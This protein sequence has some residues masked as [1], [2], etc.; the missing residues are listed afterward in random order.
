[1]AAT[2]SDRLGADGTRQRLRAKLLSGLPVTE[3][4]R[5]CAGIS[6]A[7]L[8][9]GDGPC[10]VALHGPGEFAPRWRRVIP[11]LAE[12]HRIVI[13]DLPG[14]GA[15]H[16]GAIDLTEARVMRWLYEL[17]EQT[18]SEPPTLVGHI[19]GGAIAARFAV[20]HGD[21]LGRL[22]LVD[23]L[24]LAPFRPSIRFALGMLGFLVRPK[25]STYHH[26]MA[27]CEYDRDALALDMGEQWN[28]VRDYAL[29]L[30]RDADG[31]AAVRTLMTRV[32]VPPI[33]AADLAGIEVP[34][35]L[36]WGRH[37][38][39]LRLH[40]AEAASERYGWALH[41]IE[42]TADDAPMERPAAFVQALHE[43]MNDKGM[44]G[45]D[46]RVRAGEDAVR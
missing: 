23:S 27:Q 7:V 42:N 16:A 9:G 21:M 40:I 11:A 37:D 43:S 33:P 10:I 13:P 14:H 26:F 46:P 18:C 15:S 34:T 44:P 1:M 24:G 4:R 2:R 30:A 41:V 19:L 36:I 17:I 29:E 6:T 32:G 5:E 38:R 45:T 12:T 20:E 39:A 22:V 3:R 28:A 35:S 8:E 31:K 25:E